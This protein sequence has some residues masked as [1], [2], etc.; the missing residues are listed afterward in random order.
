VGDGLARIDTKTQEVSFVPMPA[1]RQPYHVAVDSKHD[2]WTNVWMT[3]QVCATTER[4]ELDRVRPADARRRGALRVAAR[5]ERPDAGGA[6]LFPPA[7]WP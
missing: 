7:R 2:V 1:F 5:A 4:Q 3:D 6:A